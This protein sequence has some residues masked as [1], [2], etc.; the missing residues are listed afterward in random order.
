[1][2]YL[3]A[4]AD[5]PVLNLTPLPLSDA[6]DWFSR[7]PRLRL[8]HVARGNVV[9]MYICQLDINAHRDRNSILGRFP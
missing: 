4:M 3:I 9:G 5:P 7:V 1:V 8:F 2:T 6:T